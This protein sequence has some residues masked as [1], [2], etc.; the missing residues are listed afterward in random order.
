MVILDGFINPFDQ[1]VIYKCGMKLF[2]YRSI[3]ENNFR[4]DEE[5]VRSKIKNS[6]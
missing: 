6:E 3:G 4:K 1:A 2:G 5:N